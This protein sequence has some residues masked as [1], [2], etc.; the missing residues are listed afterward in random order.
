M[1]AGLGGWESTEG[2]VKYSGVPNS[3]TGFRG[4][5]VGKYSILVTQLI[6]LNASDYEIRERE[7]ILRK[8]ECIRTSFILNS[9]TFLR[10][11][12]RFPCM[13]LSHHSIICVIWG[14]GVEV[15]RTAFLLHLQSCR[16]HY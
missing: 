11:F 9:E 7:D 8:Y 13:I 6:E 10:A 14:L 1:E 5:E 16:S 3:R 4:R 2:N 15:E 12:H